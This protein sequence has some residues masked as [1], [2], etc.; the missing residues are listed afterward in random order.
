MTETAFLAA[1]TAVLFFVAQIPV[2]GPFLCV[3]CPFPVTLMIYRHGVR[4]GLVGMAAALLLVGLVQGA[5][6]L[7]ALPFLFLGGLSGILLRRRV[8]PLR[9]LFLGGVGLGLLL[10]AV[11]WPYE[12]LWAEAWG[13]RTFR[14]LA[15]DT[16]G[17]GIERVVSLRVASSGVTREVFQGSQ[18]YLVYQGLRTAAEHF[19]L[20]VSWMPF[21]VMLFFGLFGYWV[22]YLAARPILERFE[23]EMAPLPP[24][25]EWRAGPGVALLVVPALLPVLAPGLG[26]RPGEIPYLRFFLLNLQVVSQLLLAL[27]GV[28]RLD[29]W[30]A[31]WSLPWPLRR[32]V[33]VFF[34]VLPLPGPLSGF[35]VLALWG[36]VSPW[37]SSAPSSPGAREGETSP[38]A[39]PDPVPRDPSGAGA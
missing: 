26:E 30:L 22:Y 1:L 28:A 20:A 32:V 7:L 33:E 15:G 37:S 4:R 16:L 19:V 5:L 31:G 23:V 2:I 6:A 13:L 3:G 29:A 35:R 11:A 34:L 27:L 9:G 10:F 25:G 8:P 36:L 38:G 24:L 17:A 21:S 18:E 39:D 14:S 12:N